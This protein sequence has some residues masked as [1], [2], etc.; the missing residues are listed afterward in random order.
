MAIELVGTARLRLDGENLFPVADGDTGTNVLATLESG[1]EAMVG[2]DDEVVNL[3]KTVARATLI[4]A[5][6]PIAPV[7]RPSRGIRCSM[8]TCSKSHL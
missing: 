3:A 5:S 4:E 8:T 2:V 1:A 7:P 6:G